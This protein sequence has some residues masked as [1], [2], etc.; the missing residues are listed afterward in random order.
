MITY[1]Q[2]WLL[3]CGIVLLVPG[4]RE[5]RMADADVAPAPV[6]GGATRGDLV[7]PIGSDA[8]LDLATWNIENFPKRYTTPALAADLIASLRL[9][10]IALQEIADI[11]SFDEMVA[12]LPDHDGILSEHVYSSGAYQKLAVV[13]RSDLLEVVSSSLL[14][15]GET[16]PFPRPALQVDFTLAPSTGVEFD[17]SIIAVHLKA[18][19]DGSDS[20]RR[21]LA[22]EML[23]DHVG[24]VLAGPGDHDIILLGDFNE[25][26]DSAGARDVWAPMLDAPE[27][28]LVQTQ[29]ASDNLEYSFLPLGRLLD[30]IVSTT[31][32]AD[33]FAGRDARI[34]RLDRDIV[35][36]ESSLSDHLPVVISMPLSLPS[37]GS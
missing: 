5:P 24:E 19:G 3:A 23:D 28:Y 25:V 18:G 11:E 34:P 2:V 36:F 15:E 8:T 35:E 20:R 1:R 31:S 14:F 37:P 33:E 9:D 17:F 13:Y 21:K 29:A 4:C 16:H 22:F 26:L 27:R 7:P 12:H 6:D 30:H 32:L 10:I